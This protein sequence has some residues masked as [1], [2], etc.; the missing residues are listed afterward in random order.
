MYLTYERVILLVSRLPGKAG[1]R[2]MREGL[3]FFRSPA[4]YNA[5]LQERLQ[6]LG[7]MS[8]E[9]WYARPVTIEALVRPKDH[10]RFLGG[11]ELPLN[12]IFFSG[13]SIDLLLGL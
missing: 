10:Q 9:S 7:D 12:R 4:E 6:A 13:E 5:A 8:A 11:G 2:D 1:S 3:R